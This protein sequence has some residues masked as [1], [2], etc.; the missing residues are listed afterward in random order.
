MPHEM[1]V[2]HV[3]I[4]DALRLRMGALAFT[5]HIR[6]RLVVVAIVVG[7]LETQPRSALNAPN[8]HERA[9]HE[10]LRQCCRRAR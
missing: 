7:S 10:T 8:L 1:R 5:V 2:D 4:S 3:G 9:R 6:N